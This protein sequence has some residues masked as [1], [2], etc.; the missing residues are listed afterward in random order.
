[1]G[2]KRTRATNKYVNITKKDWGITYSVVYLND[3]ALFWLEKKELL[4]YIIDLKIWIKIFLK[5]CVFL[6]WHTRGAWTI[7]SDI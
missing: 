1:M 3:W 2:T 4:E 6:G 5:M 7:L